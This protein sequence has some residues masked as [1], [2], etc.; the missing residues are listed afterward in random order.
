MKSIPNV[1][2]HLT[3]SK[4]VSSHDVCSGVKS[5]QVKTKHCHSVPETFLQYQKLL[6][7][8]LFYFIESL[9]TI[10]YHASFQEIKLAKEKCTLHEFNFGGTAKIS[11]ISK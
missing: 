8:P 7:N 2:K 9:S 3:L 1:K 4:S 6:R 10:Q 11:T 5:Q